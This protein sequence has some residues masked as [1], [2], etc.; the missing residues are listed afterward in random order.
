MAFGTRDIALARSKRR[1]MDEESVGIFGVL[2]IVTALVMGH[3][4]QKS[5]A[6]PTLPDVKWQ[7]VVGV[8]SCGD[9]P[10][11]TCYLA[12]SQ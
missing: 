3:S 4:I 6:T 12:M 8:F 10:S 1:V 7:D 2:L 5:Y 9:K 11:D